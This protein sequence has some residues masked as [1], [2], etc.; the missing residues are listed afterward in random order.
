M[1]LL[2]L[3][4][5][6]GRPFSKGDS[7]HR[8][9]PSPEHDQSAPGAAGTATYS[10]GQSVSRSGSERGSERSVKP[11]KGMVLENGLDVAFVVPPL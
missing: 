8:L 4:F 1:F 7:S 9:G 11:F 3:F 5:L 6:G 2:F 10:R